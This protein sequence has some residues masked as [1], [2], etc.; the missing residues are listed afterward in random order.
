MAPAEVISFKVTVPPRSVPF[1]A[2]KFI[3]ISPAHIF[4]KGEPHVIL[5]SMP[6]IYCD[7]DEGTAETTQYLLGPK[8]IG[9]LHDL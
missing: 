1:A 3:G 7:W 2:K 6:S 8:V 4:D 9:F 5:P